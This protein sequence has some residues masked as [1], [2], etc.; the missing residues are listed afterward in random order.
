M[1]LNLKKAKKQSNNNDKEFKPL[2]EG[3]YPFVV[4]AGEVGEFKTGTPKIEFTFRCESDDYKNRKLWHSFA[5]TESAH[6]Y[7]IRFLEALGLEELTEQESVSEQQIIKAAVGKKVTAYAE[8]TTGNNGKQY[9]NLKNFA[10]VEGGSSS[11]APAAAP[12]QPAAASSS[13]G[14]KKLFT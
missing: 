11:P 3:R 4:E 1:A 14:K 9:N 12:S 5:L 13:S 7:L 10:K 2:Q 6:V 8:I